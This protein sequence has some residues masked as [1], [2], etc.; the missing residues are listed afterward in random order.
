MFHQFSHI[1]FFLIVFVK[2]LTIEMQHLLAACTEV[3]DCLMSLQRMPSPYPL[4]IF[5]A[6]FSLAQRTA[7]SFATYQI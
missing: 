2:A 4:M 1:N 3:H 7:L 5:S 6:G